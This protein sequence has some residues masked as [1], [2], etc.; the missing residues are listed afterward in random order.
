M[1][2]FIFETLFEDTLVRENFSQPIELID[3][4]GAVIATLPRDILYIDNPTTPAGFSDDQQTEH[5]FYTSSTLEQFVDEGKGIFKKGE[6]YGLMDN[7]GQVALDFKYQYLSDQEY[8]Y[9]HC[10]IILC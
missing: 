4:T 6:S 1:R 8:K 9:I 5:P 10:Y 7:K 2:P 3:S